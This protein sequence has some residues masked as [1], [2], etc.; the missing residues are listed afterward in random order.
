LPVD[1]CCIGEIT[2]PP[3]EAGPVE[4]D[5]LAAL[6]ARDL[7]QAELSLVLTDDATIQQLNRDYRGIDSPTDVLSFAQ[8]EAEG[9]AG[10]ILGDLI[11]SLPTAR[12]QARERGHS[13]AVEVRMLMV[14]GL[15]HLLGYDHETEE[16][17][18]EMAAAEQAL[19]AALPLGP[20]G[21]TTTGIVSLGES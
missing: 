19:L 3:P 1:L 9:P 18:T 12:R 20:E 5:A 14:H 10:S 17:R 8:Q 13:L 21:P 16:Q 4:A 7:A 6:M 2:A 15:L 11:I